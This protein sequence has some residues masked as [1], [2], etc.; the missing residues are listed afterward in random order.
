MFT[1]YLFTV[2]CRNP[3]LET[4]KGKDSK[5][6]SANY[7]SLEMPTLMIYKQAIPLKE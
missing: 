6:E 3:V 1:C 4:T 5:S 2:Y 7:I